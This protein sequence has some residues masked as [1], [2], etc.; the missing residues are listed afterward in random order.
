MK[1]LALSVAAVWAALATCPARAAE[2]MP[3]QRLA[4]CQ[5]SWLDWK[6]DDARMARLVN[7]FESGFTR[8]AEGAFTPKSALSVLGHPVTSV[9]PQSVGM[10]VGFSLV[11]Q[12]GFAETRAAIEKQLGKPMACSTS[13]G[14]RSC[15]LE[16]GA[17]RTA[18]LMTGQNGLAKSSLVGC[19]Y[20]Y[21]Q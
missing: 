1:T 5:D 8:G 7:S 17:R 4:L 3:L 19:Y 6:N 10:G 18:V 11:V 12:A 2:D 13:E 21:Q 20:F 9:Y 14:T 16:I 15:E